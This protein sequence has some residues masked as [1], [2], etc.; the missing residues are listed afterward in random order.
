MPAH[1]QQHHKQERRRDSH[2]NRALPVRKSVQPVSHRPQHCNQLRFTATLAVIFVFDVRARLALLRPIFGH[3]VEFRL[4]CF[5]RRGFALRFSFGVFGNQC[6]QQLR[7]LRVVL[8]RFFLSLRRL[9][10]HFGQPCGAL[11]RSRFRRLSSLRRNRRSHFTR[12]RAALRNRRRIR[13]RVGYPQHFFL[14]LNRF[15][16]R[17]RSR[18]HWSRRR[19][20][21]HHRSIPKIWV[22]R[23]EFQVHVTRL[24]HLPPLQYL[25]Q[26]FSSGALVA[27]KNTLP[28]RHFRA[29][30]HHRAVPEDDGRLGRL[31]KYLAL[32]RSL[33][34]LR[35]L[36]R[37]RDFQHRRLIACGGISHYSSHH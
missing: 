2:L 30:I 4:F 27:Q 32:L 33:D 18:N 8:R 34:V 3:C 15:R 10:H 24:G 35:P 19:R 12:R 16:R 5:C 20:L 14:R 37:H 13:G 23:R 28:L 26:N 29:Q 36:N 31:R 17:S 9:F 7:V 11:H 21:L 22:A 1:S 25:A 6:G